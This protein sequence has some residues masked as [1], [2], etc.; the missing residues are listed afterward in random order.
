MHMHDGC[1]TGA[2]GRPIRSVADMRAAAKDI[3]ALGPAYV[4]VKGGHLTQSGMAPDT[5]TAA[6][7]GAGGTEVEQT[8][9]R[10]ATAAAAAAG[11]G[12]GGGVA[13]ESG[14]QQKV[15]V[16]VLYDGKEW[17][18]LRGPWVETSNTHGTGCT[19]AAAIVAGLA[20]GMGE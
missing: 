13:P 20:Q 19:L 16:D 9:G 17:H 15:A 14:A 1:M 10:T 3:H 11:G 7:G 2:G 8:Q 6:D 12:G 5:A 4:L 18:E